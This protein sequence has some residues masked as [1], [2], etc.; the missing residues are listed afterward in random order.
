[1]S[2][3]IGI[4]AY[5]EEL[6]IQ[7]L[8]N[9][10]L[11]SNNIFGSLNELIIISDGSTDSTVARIK[12]IKNKKIVLI[13]KSKRRGKAIQENL[14]F[15]RCESEYLIILD[16]DILP[17]HDLIDLFLKEFADNSRLSLVS[18]RIQSVQPRT[19]V[20]R[21]LAHSQLIMQ[22]IYQQIG[23]GNSIYT[24]NGRALGYRKSFYKSIVLP[25]NIVADDAYIYLN[26][27]SK[28]YLYKQIQSAVVNYRLPCT[29]EDHYR[30]SARFSSS[31]IQ[32]Q[33][34]FPKE[35]LDT[36]FKIPKQTIALAFQKA[37]MANPLH[38][39]TYLIIMVYIKL[40]YYLDKK[41]VYESRWK[42]SQSSKMIL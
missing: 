20:E 40:K 32:L 30:Q 22:S 28:K 1:M 35:F 23:E 21:V 34:F 25:K 15:Q 26:C 4:V 18:G 13:A 8:I 24:C 41:V 3:S 31:Q 9:S 36:A 39:L 17:D 33:N 12:Q 27:I 16:A 6:N 42:V 29:L 19:F 38:T 5:N 2:Y 11:L 10:L 7:K 14:L 37:L